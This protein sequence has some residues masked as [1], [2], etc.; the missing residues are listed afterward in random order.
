MVWHDVKKEFSKDFIIFHARSVRV[1]HH[2]PPLLRIRELPN[3]DGQPW[4]VHGGQRYE[5]NRLGAFKPNNQAPSR[6]LIIV[7]GGCST[8]WTYTAKLV[9]AGIQVRLVAQP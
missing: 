7:I 5:P 2:H 3:W 4:D 1:F 9:H 8:S 6:A